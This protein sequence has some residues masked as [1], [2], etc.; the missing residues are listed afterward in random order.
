[1]AH[2]LTVAHAVTPEGVIDDATIVIEG[3]RIVSI[4]PAGGGG[5]LWAVPGFVDTHCHGAV[6]VSFGDPDPARN[7]EAIAYHRTHGTTTIFASTVTEPLEKLEAQ[8]AVLR[9]LY[10]AGDLAGI[11]LEGPF[12]ATERKGAHDEALLRVPDPA[13]VERLIS[14][15]G[16]ALRMITLAVE[17]EHAEVATRR[18]I[19]AGVAVAFGHS[20][21]DD[22]Q[23]A[24]SIEWGATVATHLFSAMRSIHHRDP[25]PVPVLLADQRVM[26]ELI[27]D[28]VHHKP[29]IAAMSIDA[30]TPRRVALVTDAMSATGKGD[31]RYILGELEVEVSGGTARLVTADGAPGAIAGSTLTMDK[32]FEFVV[33]EVGVSIPDAALMAA[34]TPAAWHRLDD[35]GRLAPGCWADVCLVDDDGRL[36]AVMRRGEWVVPPRP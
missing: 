20:D 16:P 11:H 1:M 21:A 35:V 36:H 14:A 25:G 19:E 27:C 13:S 15:G 7:L 4:E 18:F 22:I 26:V 28:G 5:A 33:Q 8:L 3:G 32:A 29:V 9:A 6:G 30:A 34:T 31:G 10:D 23:T 17:L 12:L 2:Q 24:E